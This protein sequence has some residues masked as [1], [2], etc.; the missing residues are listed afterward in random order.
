MADKIRLVKML[1]GE[2]AVWKCPGCKTDHRALT[3][4]WRFNGDMKKPTIIPDVVWIENGQE[5][6]CHSNIVDGKVYFFPDTTANNMQ[7]KTVNL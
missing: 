1:D 7:G 6:I 3:T 2:A 5:A 4:V